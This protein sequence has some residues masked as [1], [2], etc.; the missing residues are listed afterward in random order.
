MSSKIYLYNFSATRDPFY[1]LA[2]MIAHVELRYVTKCDVIT[3]SVTMGYGGP[4]ASVS[5]TFSLNFRP[6]IDPPS[7][8]TKL[9]HRVKHGQR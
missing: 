6:K 1:R 7:F 8:W 3:V 4:K 2:I 9:C 5:H